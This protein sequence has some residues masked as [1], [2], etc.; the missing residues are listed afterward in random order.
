MIFKVK[1]KNFG[2]LENEEFSINNFTVLAGP[3]NSG[4]SFLSKILYSI[5]KALRANHAKAYLSKQFAP[6]GVE[7]RWFVKPRFE[8]ADEY[9]VDED[10][11]TL[12]SLIDSCH[13]GNIEEL[14]SIVAQIVSQID[15][16]I[17]K[18]ALIRVNLP[19]KKRRKS[20]RNAKVHQSIAELAD[21][22]IDFRNNLTDLTAIEIM[23]HGMEFELGQKIKDNFQVASFSQLACKEKLPIVIEI[24]DIGKFKFSD[25]KLSIGLDETWREN[26][27]PFSRLIYIESPIFLKL[28]TA[29]EESKHFLRPPW[30]DRKPITGVPE[31]FYDLARVLRF[32]YTG[33]IAFPDLYEKLTSESILGGKLAISEEGNLS[34][35]ENDRR[36]S[37]MLTATGIANIGF[38]ALLIERKIL[39]ENSFIFIDEPEAHLHPAWQVLMAATLFELAKK[40]VHVVIATHSIDILKWVDVHVKKN[41]NDRKYIALN[42]F[43]QLPKSGGIDDDNFDD[44]LAAIKEELIKPFSDLYIEGL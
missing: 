15:K 31:Y 3:N 24:D 23:S 35:L 26:V 7:W 43:N 44:K 38:L 12:A 10:L 30:F 25:G 32:E 21:S 11:E 14:T 17:E 29:L 2:K 34:F 33:D 37:L 1:I 40:G 39:D 41:P 36:F 9:L 8:T 5:F 16:V 13:T 6:I 18:C 22:L 4:K 27:L 20:R 28:K 19:M 42:R